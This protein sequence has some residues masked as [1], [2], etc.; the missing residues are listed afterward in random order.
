[1]QLS[2]K[3]AVAEYLLQYSKCAS[4]HDTQY[5]HS[6][7]I[8]TATVYNTKSELYGDQLSVSEALWGLHHR[9]KKK[10][11]RNDIKQLSLTTFRTKIL[12][13]STR[14]WIRMA[15]EFVMAIIFFLTE[16]SDSLNR[17]LL[18][19]FQRWCYIRSLSPKKVRVKWW[20]PR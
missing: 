11:P 4:F 17:K 3:D 19:N 6:T 1:M 5:P 13:K 16:I 12:L 18:T 20:K 10:Q 8:H 7:V 14:K 9:E 15:Y 2:A